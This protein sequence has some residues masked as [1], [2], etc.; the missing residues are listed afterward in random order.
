MAI[1]ISESY[2]KK[3]ALTDEEQNLLKGSCQKFIEKFVINILLE[4]G[5]RV[6]EFIRLCTKIFMESQRNKSNFNKEDYNVIDWQNNEIIVYG[7]KTKQSK[8]KGERKRRIVPLSNIAKNYLDKYFSIEENEKIDYTTTA[9]WYLVKRVAKR[10]DIKKDVSP[11][12]LRHTFAVNYL[13]RGGKLATLQRILGHTS[14][15][16]TS[17]YLTMTSAD[18]QKEFSEVMK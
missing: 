10:A 12:I 5:L 2:I 11:H 4:T 17:I 14:L 1:N 16:T 6:D 7:K 9:L 3:E 8:G 13:K 15:Q 18:I